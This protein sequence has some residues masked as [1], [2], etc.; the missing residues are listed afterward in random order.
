MPGGSV[1][2]GACRL[3]LKLAPQLKD[4]IGSHVTLRQFLLE[5]FDDRRVAGSSVE[6]SVARNQWSPELSAS[7]T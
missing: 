1:E 7:P 5:Q 6:P 3:D 4:S 2:K